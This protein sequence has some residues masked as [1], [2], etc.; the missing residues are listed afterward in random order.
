MWSRWPTA[1]RSG[2]ATNCTASAGRPVSAAASA[3]IFGDRGVGV[4]GL[5]PAAKDHGVAALDAN[6]RRVG[7]HVRPRLVD[8]EDHPQRHADLLHFQ[9]VG[10]DRGGDHLADRLRQGGDSSI[11]LAI[12]AMRGESAASGRFGRRSVHS[13]GRPPGQKWLASARAAERSA[14]KRAQQR[15]HCCFCPPLTVASSAA[16]AFAR[17]ARSRQYCCKSSMDKTRPSAATAPLSGNWR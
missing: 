10:P 12:S 1:A 9:P 17:R 3:R 13:P 4:G 7:R 5:L 15:S 16:A 6:G 14:S 2:V 8:E 11:A